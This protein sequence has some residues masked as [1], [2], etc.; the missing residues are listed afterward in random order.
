MIANLVCVLH[1]VA[2]CERLFSKFEWF[3]LSLE[4]FHFLCQISNTLQNNICIFLPVQ[5]HQSKLTQLCARLKLQV[6]G[7]FQIKMIYQYST[8]ICSC[9]SNHFQ[10]VSK[11]NDRIQI[12]AKWPRIIVLYIWMPLIWKKHNNGQCCFLVFLQI[13]TLFPQDMFY[14]SHL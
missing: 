6:A 7:F 11:K 9:Y 14:Q 10:V 5:L 3:Y 8:Y 12:M 2:Y 4:V 1:Y 13:G